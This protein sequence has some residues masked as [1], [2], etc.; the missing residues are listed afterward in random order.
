[1]FH[2]R[3]AKH[4]IYCIARAVHSLEIYASQLLS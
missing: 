3:Y 1:M 4:M 2:L